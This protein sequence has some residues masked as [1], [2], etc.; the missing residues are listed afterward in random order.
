MDARLAGLIGCLM[1]GS[2]C[3]PGQERRPAPE[4]HRRGG[5]EDDGGGQ[6]DGSAGGSSGGLPW[7][8]DRC[9]RDRADRAD[10]DPLAAAYAPDLS[11]VAL[12]EPWVAYLTYPDATGADRT[13]GVAL[14]L[15]EDAAAPS[16]VVVWSHG[17]ASG[18]DRPQHVGL[19]W[20]Q[21]FVGGGYAFAAIAHPGRDEASKAALCTALELGDACAT[22]KPLGWDRPN[23][24]AV[25][26]DW[27]EYA[28][29]A[30]PDRLDAARL[31]YGG[32][33]A[34]AGSALTVAGA[35]RDFAG[36]GALVSIDDPRPSA[37]LMASPQA[38]DED[39][40]V[41]GSFTG[42]ERPVLALSGEGDDVADTSSDERRATFDLL[43]G[44]NRHL[45]WLTPESATHATFD[46]EVDP[47][48]ELL[49][50]ADDEDA[51]VCASYTR[52]LES[53]A[54]AF[55]D[56]EL[57]GDP[58]AAAWL[59]GDGFAALSGGLGALTSP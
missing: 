26:A 20:A 4:A 31:M 33:S 30:H 11:G 21:V 22:F 52:W 54:L 25:V 15:P 45:A 24:F 13:V 51:G 7:H 32:H 6:G 56:A 47:C 44:P 29:D 17:G 40:F 2:A 5:P 38:P 34:G 41:A 39:G 27:L 12:P 36:T 14:Y 48:E 19:G 49:A 46:H 55:A 43:T 23:D 1:C 53:P 8:A 10:P 16:P 57:R 18:V 9:D 35:R 50:R 42:V 37:F 59:L 3:A 28:A 58:E